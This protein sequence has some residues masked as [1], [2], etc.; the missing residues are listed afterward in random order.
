MK[1]IALVLFNN[2]KGEIL[3]HLKDDKSPTIFPDY[4]S[5]PEGFLEEGGAEAG[6]LVR[7]MMEE[8]SIDPRSFHFFNRYEY[9]D[10]TSNK[11]FELFVFTCR[12][13]LHILKITLHEGQ[14]VDYVHP[15]YLHLVNIHP[16]IKR[17]IKD[18]SRLT[19]E[20]K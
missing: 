13:N 20:K 5:L 9:I 1:R 17:I 3:L 10:E 7:G 16:I 2:N 6:T 19:V 12:I 8:H 18:F 11:K 14:K 15:M 4:W